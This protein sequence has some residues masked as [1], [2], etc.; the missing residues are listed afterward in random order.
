MSKRGDIEF[1]MD[2]QESVKRILI[3]TIQAPIVSL[4][5]D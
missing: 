5:G 4:R 1:L 2:I 3:V